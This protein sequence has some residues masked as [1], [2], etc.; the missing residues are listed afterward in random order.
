MRMRRVY[1]LAV[2]P[3]GFGLQKADQL[4]EPLALDRIVG[5]FLVARFVTEDDR[6]PVLPRLILSPVN[7]CGHPAVDVPALELLAQRF[8]SVHPSLDSH[9]RNRAEH[10]DYRTQLARS[11]TSL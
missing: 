9:S 1:H 6:Y 8:E 4:A 7:V 3:L 11:E 2:V 10:A 5:V